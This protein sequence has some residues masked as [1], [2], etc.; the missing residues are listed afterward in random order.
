MTTLR[1]WGRSAL[2][3]FPAAGASL[4][5]CKSRSLIVL[6]GSER[7]EEAAISWPLA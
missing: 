5:L 7:A 6:G 2:K 3:S 1:P 4:D